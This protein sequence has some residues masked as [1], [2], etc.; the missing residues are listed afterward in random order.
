[1]FSLTLEKLTLKKLFDWIEEVNEMNVGEVICTSIDHEGKMNGFDIN[2]LLRLNKK[3]N[4]P[5]IA[6]GGAALL[7]TP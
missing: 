3:L 2:T 7:L 6:A 1:M 4:S 5:M